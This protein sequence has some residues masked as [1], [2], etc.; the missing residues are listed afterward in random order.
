MGARCVVQMTDLHLATRCR[1]DLEYRD[2]DIT[3]R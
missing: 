2:R 3:V 1:L